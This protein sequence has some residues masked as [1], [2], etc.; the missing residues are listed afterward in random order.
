M[1][2]LP[3]QAQSKQ[4]GHPS[5]QAT[6]S[7]ST[8]SGTSTAHLLHWY[9][10]LATQLHVLALALALELAQVVHK[11]CRHTAQPGAVLKSLVLLLT[12]I[13]H[14]ASNVNIHRTNTRCTVDA[15]ELRYY[16]H[17]PSL[18]V[19]SCWD[20]TAQAMRWY[21]FSCWLKYCANPVRLQS[22]QHRWGPAPRSSLEAIPS[23][24]TRIFSLF[25]V[26]PTQVEPTQ[27]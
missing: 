17:G 18:I 1:G 6:P 26:S 25:E 20:N 4:Q 7:I 9:S 5:K 22:P 10:Y 13:L 12:L 24:T 11:Y 14:C 16:M 3:G 15:L 2:G 27:S 8:R 19:Y 23:S 21:L